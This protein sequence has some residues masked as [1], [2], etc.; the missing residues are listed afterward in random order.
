M[1]FANAFPDTYEAYSQSS[2]LLIALLIIGI[3]ASGVA[4]VL[5]A[6]YALKTLRGLQLDAHTDKLSDL[7][8]RRGLEKAANNMFAHVQNVSENIFVLMI[9]IDHFKRLND[10]HGHAFG[11]E[12][13]TQLGRLLNNS[14][15]EGAVAARLGGEEFVALF[16]DTDMGAALEKAENLR[17]SIGALCLYS[18]KGPVSFTVSLGVARHVAGEPLHDLLR[19]ADAALY[20]AKDGGRNCVCSEID[21]SIETLRELSGGRH[22][23]VS[24]RAG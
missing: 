24:S 12:V 19:R 23:S 1:K 5:I 2:F 6:D 9:D 8:N 14:M 21:V 20:R 10:T 11:D 7:L 13:I 4:A 15:I 3:N 18:A 17:H 16:A 22:K